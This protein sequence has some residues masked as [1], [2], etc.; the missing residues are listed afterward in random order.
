MIDPFPTASADR[1]DIDGLSVSIFHI[2]VFL[3]FPPFRTI[4]ISDHVPRRDL[5]LPH[6]ASRS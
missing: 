1:L 6:Q 3:S 4:D 5:F 2:L